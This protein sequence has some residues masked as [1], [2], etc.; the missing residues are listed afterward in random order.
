MEETTWQKSAATGA[1]GMPGAD[2]QWAAIFSYVSPEQR[3]PA[4]LR[5]SDAVAKRPQTGL[6]A[7]ACGDCASSAD[8]H[9]AL[10]PPTPPSPATSAPRSRAAGSGWSTAAARSG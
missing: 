8:P 4:A 3:V 10:A 6:N 2:G 5:A 1:R 7:V 9:G